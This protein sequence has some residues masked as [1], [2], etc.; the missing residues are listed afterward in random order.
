LYLFYFDKKICD[1]LFDAKTKLQNVN[2]VLGNASIRVYVKSVIVLSNV[3]GFVILEEIFID[4]TSSLEIASL[5]GGCIV[6]T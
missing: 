6:K 5:R 3:M 4:V 2:F 1:A